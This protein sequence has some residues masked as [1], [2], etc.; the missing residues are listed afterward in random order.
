[1][2]EKQIKALQRHVGTLDDGDWGPKSRKACEAHLRR[3]M[4]NSSPWP[5]SHQSS[6]RSFYG[7]PDD[8]SQIIRVEAPEWMKLYNSDKNLK[9][10]WVH[11]KCA[12]SLMRALESAHSK[13]PKFASKYFGCHVDRNMR[14]GSKPSTHAY[15]A[16]IDLSASTNRNKQSWPQDAD[17]PI[18]VME[19]FSKEGWVAA[20][21]FWG[22]DA[23]H[24]Q[25]T[26]I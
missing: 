13:S 10:I 17:M 3:L 26:Q 21:A 4:P 1:M 2:T 5:K 23:M 18:E 20:G 11:E 14:G 19:E 12:D 22:S 15:G 9:N 25:A 7:A 6:L 8:N 24:F 16:A